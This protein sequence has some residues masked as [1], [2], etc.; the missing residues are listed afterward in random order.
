VAAKASKINKLQSRRF[1][2]SEPFRCTTL[3][4]LGSQSPSR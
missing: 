1:T 2:I 3:T 4:H